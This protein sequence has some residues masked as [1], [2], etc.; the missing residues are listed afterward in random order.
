MVRE[1]GGNDGDWRVDIYFM[2]DQDIVPAGSDSAAPLKIQTDISEGMTTA[3]QT[4]D[5]KLQ[6]VDNA[7]PTPPVSPSSASAETEAAQQP[8]LSKNAQKRLL[9]EERWKANAPERRAKRKQRKAEFKNK[10][11]RL[12]QEGEV[13]NHFELELEEWCQHILLLST[14]VP[15]QPKKKIKKS[16]VTFHNI[17][18]VIDC[19]FEEFMVLDK[20]YKSLQR[21][22][23]Q[24]YAVNRRSEH[25]LKLSVT[26]MGARLTQTFQEKVP[27]Y[28]E[29]EMKFQSTD[30][31]SNFASEKDQIVYLTADTPNEISTLEEGAIYVIGGLVDKNRHKGLTYQRAI[32]KG[33]NVAQLPIGQYLKL[34]QRKVLT[35]NHGGSCPRRSV[36]SW[37]YSHDAEL[38]VFEIL[39]RFVETNDWKI[40]L[41]DVIP[42]RKLH[43]VS[44]SSRRRGRADIEEGEPGEEIKESSSESEESSNESCNDD[45]ELENL[46]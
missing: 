17:R 1:S 44:R 42:Q 13:L 22:I 28:T 36:C 45:A 7:D 14:G 12:A 38:S 27:E 34:T 15:L 5:A 6:N 41:T 31:L 2:E 23:Q 40:A 11:R 16:D 30:Y 43:S 25:Q 20:D 9:K 29:W 21:Q 19:D 3:V 33:I 18:V 26:G 39:S 46:S 4:Q 35:V 10:Q 32:E 8:K 24:C 37:M